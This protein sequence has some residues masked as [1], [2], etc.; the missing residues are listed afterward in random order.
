MAAEL[1]VFTS[2]AF[3]KGGTSFAAEDAAPVA[4]TVAG[5]KAIKHRQTIGTSEEAIVL[6]EV[7]PAGAYYKFT[8]RDATNYA[9]I[10]MSSGGANAVQIGPGESACGRFP[11]GVTAPFAIANSAP[12]DIEYVLIPA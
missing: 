7:T 1:K 8:N 3:A 11:V 10:R 6:G 9:S 12:V 5:S 4:I 2:V